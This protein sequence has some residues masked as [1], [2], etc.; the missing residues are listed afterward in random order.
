MPVTRHARDEDG[1]AMVTSIVLTGLMLVMGLALLSIV[2]T[3]AKQSR[4]ERVSDSS[5]NLAEGALNAEAFLLSRN[6]P[7]TAPTASS[8]S[9][10]ASINGDLATSSA[11]QRILTDSFTNSDYATTSTWKVNVCDDTNSTSD[12]WSDSKL[13]SAY[14]YDQ[15]QNGKLWVRAQTTVRGQSRAVAALVV[16]QHPPIMPGGYAVLGGGVATSLS[17]VTNS[18]LASSTLLGQLTTDLLNKNND[19]LVDDGKI[20]VRCGLTSLCAD[21]VFTGLSSTTLGPLLLANDWVQYGST[22]AVNDDTIAD[23]RDQAKNK[24]TGVDTYVASVA[25]NGSCIPSNATTSS[26]VFV[27]LVGDGT[28][29]CTVNAATN[30]TVKMLVVANGRISISGNGTFT[31][32]VYGL[33]RQRLTVSGGDDRAARSCTNLTNVLVA[34]NPCEI[35]SITSPAKV[36]GAVYADGATGDV[37]MYASAPTNST[38]TTYP[39]I[40]LTLAQLGLALTATNVSVTASI[41]STNALSLINGNAT[42]LTLNVTATLPLVGT[43]TSHPTVSVNLVNLSA[44]NQLALVDQVVGDM[45]GPIVDYDKATVDLVTGFGSSGTVAG[46]FRAIPPN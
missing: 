15:N 21:G 27:E 45:R 7:T 8:C 38:C 32:V 16:V 1:W 12:T 19:K 40:G 6:W 46:T 28:Q 11:V 42:S 39:I 18:L 4:T 36:K 23:F 9:T 44:A 31:G 34:T 33:N 2:D 22:A 20:G 3:Q 14:G 37:G 25:A 5:F 43:V 17:F 10:T 29:T 26:V 13:S 41:C 35:V 24:I 30:P